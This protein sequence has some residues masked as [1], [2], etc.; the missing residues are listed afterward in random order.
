MAAAPAPAR[1]R[2]PGEQARPSAVRP[3]SAPPSGLRLTR[4]GRI[5]L[6]GFALTLIL[7]LI[8]VAW[9][10]L[11]GGAQA[12]DHR[13]PGGSVYQGM[14]Q[15][16]V[17]PGQTLWTIAEHAEPSADPRLVIQQIMQFNAISGTNLQPGQ[18]LWVPRG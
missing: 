15:V 13:S 16:T 6:S 9:A 17:L 12:A 14:H 4:R 10:G 3:R 18:Q 11:A 5:V 1:E 8:T 2:R 7:A